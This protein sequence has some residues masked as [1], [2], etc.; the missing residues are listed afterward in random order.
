M[1]LLSSKQRRADILNLWPMICTF[2]QLGK[3]RPDMMRGAESKLRQY[4][5]YI[6][7]LAA[8]KQS[9]LEMQESIIRGGES[10][11]Y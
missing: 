9:F 11:A 1:G 2:G 7:Q 4:G 5:P 3:D 6:V 8:F 10:H